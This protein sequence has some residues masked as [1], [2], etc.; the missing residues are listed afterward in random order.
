MKTKN[1]FLNTALVVTVFAAVAVCALLRVW[2]P[3]L[4]LP[5]AD[6]PGMLGLCL[7]ALLADHYAAKGAK[8]CYICV[9]VFGALSFGLLPFCAGFV[10]LGNALWMALQGGLVFTVSVW[11]FDA[12]MDRL[13][14]GPKA[15]LAPVL[16]ALCLFLAAQAM[17]GMGF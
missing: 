11:L 14:T 8:R 9:P 16:C 13:S 2:L 10:T 6:V 17:A 15:V 12:M 7:V 3:R 1:W 5:A 4:V